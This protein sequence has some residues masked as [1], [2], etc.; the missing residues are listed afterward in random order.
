VKTSA[1]TLLYRDGPNGLE[2]LL[3]HASG[4]YNRRAPWGIPKGLPDENESLESAARRETE[5][6]TGVRAGELFALGDVAYTKT[7]KRVHCFAG[8]APAVCAPRCASWEVD[9]AEFLALDEAKRRIHPDQLA[10]LERL[11]DLAGSGA[12]P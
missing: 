11:A 5:E 9:C 10:L 3:V 12:L 6:E 8:R 4:N 7:R 1:G 2:V